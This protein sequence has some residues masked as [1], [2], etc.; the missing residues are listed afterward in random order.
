M[1]R[2]TTP[3]PLSEAVGQRIRLLRKGQGL[4]AEKLAYQS[5]V[6]SKGYISDIEAGL[7]SPSLATLQK[8]A[9]H[10]EVDLLDLLTFPESS[11]RHRVIDESRGMSETALKKLLRSLE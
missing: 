5:E 7:A 10:L 2:R 3:D 11:T 1:P 8:I 6:G 9:D 4:T